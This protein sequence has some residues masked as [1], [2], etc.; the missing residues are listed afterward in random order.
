MNLALALALL[1][2]T[3]PGG[4][5][6]SGVSTTLAEIRPATAASEPAPTDTLVRIPGSPLRLGWDPERTSVLGAFRLTASEGGTIARDGETT[7][8]GDQAKTHLTFR[9]GRLSSVR[10]AATHPTPRLVS[11]VPDDLRRRGYRRVRLEENSGG[12]TSEWVGPARA[13]LTLSDA[14]VTAEFSPAPPPGKG[15]QPAARSASAPTETLDF[16]APGG[17]DSL[18]P[19]RRSA[20]PGD[21][22]RPREAVEAS[23]FGRVMVLADVDTSGVVSH[24]E[25]LRGIRELNTAALDWAALVRFEPYR[26]LGRAARFRITIPVAFLPVRVAGSKP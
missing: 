15:G 21:P 7:W 11:Y 3:P 5:A 25:I 23:V 13:V 12:S 16:T 6:P 10:L 17:T 9:D 2:E 22:V 20:M 19:P 24:V 8:F 26:H 14:S 1:V 4:P 18:P